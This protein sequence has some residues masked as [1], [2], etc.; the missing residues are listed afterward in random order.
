MCVCAGNLVTSRNAL[1][2]M[3]SRGQTVQHAKILF[4]KIKNKKQRILLLKVEIFQ[5]LASHHGAPCSA[6]IDFM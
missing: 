4:K 1:I 5:L 2:C 3:S 6:S